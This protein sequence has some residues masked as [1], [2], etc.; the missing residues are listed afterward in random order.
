MSRTLIYFQYV[1]ISSREQ[2][3]GPLHKLF[4]HFLKRLLAHC[5]SSE[6]LAEIRWIVNNLN[7]LAFKPSIQE[8]RAAAAASSGAC[9]L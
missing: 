7:L 4:I 9:G 3:N 1:R 6:E 2:D 8:Q 5:M